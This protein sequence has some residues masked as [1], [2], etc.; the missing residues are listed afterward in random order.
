VKPSRKY[1]DAATITAVLGQDGT[2]A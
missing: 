1:I 2:P